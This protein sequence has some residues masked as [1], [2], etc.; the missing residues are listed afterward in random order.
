MINELGF[1]T[2][3]MSMIEGELTQLERMLE[4]MKS[5]EVQMAYLRG[6]RMRLTQMKLVMEERRNELQQCDGDEDLLG[7]W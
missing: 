1:I 5:D 6:E 2:K 4:V 7:D 3:V